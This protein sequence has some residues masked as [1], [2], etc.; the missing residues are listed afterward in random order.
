MSFVSIL[1]EIL[2]VIIAI[3]VIIGL[4]WLLL[5]YIFHF[6]VSPNMNATYT[7]SKKDFEED[8]ITPIKKKL[9]TQN[10]EYVFEWDTESGKYSVEFGEGRKL[11]DGLL[12]VRY[13]NNWY[14]TSPTRKEKKLIF[15]ADVESSE[16]P[17]NFQDI[18]GDFYRITIEWTLE[19]TP[20]R[21]KTHINM[22]KKASI[23]VK[24][25]DLP[26]GSDTIENVNCIFFQI[27]FPDGLEGCT[28]EKF[29]DP[30]FM[31]PCFENQSPNKRM[32][33]YKN[34]IFS[35]P[36]KKI[37][38]TTAPRVFFDD[39]LN[40]F[41]ISAMD[42]YVIHLSKVDGNKITCGLE[43]EIEVVEPGFSSNYLLLFGSG[44]NDT[45]EIMGDIQRKYHGKD[46]K[47]MYMDVVDGYLGYWTDNGAYYY[48]R[49]IKNM[50]LSETLV[51]VNEHAE[52]I[53]LPLKYF[54]LD[55]WWY[56]K[57][58]E[59]WKRK[60]LGNV[61]RIL[62]GGLYGGTIEWTPDPTTMH[63][64][65]SEL[66][67][68]L[69]APIIAHNRWY[70]AETT[71]NKDFDFHI[72]K[73]KAVCIDR[74]FWDLIMKNCE[75]WNIQVYEQDWMN[76][77][78]K[79]FKMLRDQTG[80]ADEWLMNMG[81]AA[82]EHGRTIQ[83]CMANPGMFLTSVKLDAVS[84]AR[85][86]G[87]YHPRW[88]RSYDYRF[89]V[90]TSML[91]YALRLWP[92]KD[93]YRSTCEGPINGEKMPE[94]MTIVSN[95]SCGP[96]G[97][98]DKIGQFG[99]KY[100]MKTCRKDGLLLKPDKSLRAIDLMFLPNA[101][102][103]TAATHS[104][105][106]DMTWYYVLINRLKLRKAL[107]PTIS[108]NNL[109]IDVEK[110]VAYDYREQKFALIDTESPLIHDLPIRGY[111]YWIIAPYITEG[112][113][114]IGD[115][116][117]YATMNF[118]T[119][120]D[121]KVTTTSCIIQVASIQG[122]QVRLLFYDDESI[123]SCEIDMNQ[124]DTK[125]MEIQNVDLPGAKSSENMRYYDSDKKMSVITVNF[126]KAGLKKVKISFRNF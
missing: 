113:A 76:N 34:T 99:K 78:I 37:A 12:K 105:V 124:V 64:D 106:S 13:N 32:L 109:E 57:E 56:K 87:D 42:E 104:R 53:D 71:R 40:T 7:Y 75:K 44:I 41:L 43:G 18:E 82:K 55:S 79:A 116:A 50:K 24:E 52:E 66:S 4:V 17:K 100:L 81:Q 11:T 58:V 8:G 30:I 5:P 61:G 84:H 46:R 126:K 107:D 16:K 125:N 118:K 123:K 19:Q 35:P 48:Y 110:M 122:E 114:L 86:G 10:N 90:Q 38:T 15:R 85:S 91:S 108:L 115:S 51:K 119:F 98:G 65:V 95:L 28:T 31:F 1:L 68:T 25:P 29:D 88:P 6:F 49:P 22:Y 74:D 23:T 83:Y 47:S 36:G 89:F 96:V 103:F 60:A 21:L 59:E 112:L 93:V 45:L 111:K 62:G 54:D 80:N 26:A 3:L 2:E 121:I 117:K 63:C 70:S 92:F 20:I 67:E 73:D 27:E 101:K 9:S 77:Q 39:D 14:S 69:N 33:S 120:D 102:Y 94:F 97:P 72:E